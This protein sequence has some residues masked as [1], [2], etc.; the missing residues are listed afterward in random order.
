MH[1]T[2]LCTRWRKRNETIPELVQAINRLVRK[3]FPTANESTHNYMGVSSFI[4]ALNNDQ[5]E[6]FVFQRD[7][8]NVEEA[9]WAA[10]AYETFQSSKPKTGPP[11]VRAQNMEG[12]TPGNTAHRPVLI[13]TGRSVGQIGEKS[14]TEPEPPKCKFQQRGF[15]F[16]ALL[17]L[18]P[19]RTLAK[20]MPWTA[21][22]LKSWFLIISLELYRPT[23]V[24]NL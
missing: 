11:Y 6:M 15:T 4:S 5:H 17:Q 18:S 2:E 14:S 21:A 12:T 19:D 8:Q 10:M 9:G 16:R 7:P 22:E 13:R 3:A 20:C 24:S 23:T 1:Q